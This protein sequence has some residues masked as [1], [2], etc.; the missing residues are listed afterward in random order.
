VEICDQ[1]RWR[2]PLPSPGHPGQGGLGF[3]L[4]RRLVDCVLIRHDARGTKVLLRHPMS[5][6]APDRA[7]SAHGHHR[8]Y[9]TPGRSHG[10]VGAEKRGVVTTDAAVSSS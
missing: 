5:D 6:P 7:P 9:R 2:E 3:V 10:A 4:M 1:G 8:W